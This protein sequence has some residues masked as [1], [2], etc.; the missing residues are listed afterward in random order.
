MVSHIYLFVLAVLAA[1]YIGSF[2]SHTETESHESASE[3][4]STIIEYLSSTYMEA[5]T[6]LGYNIV[7]GYLEMKKHG[8]PKD[9]GIWRRVHNVIDTP[10]VRRYGQSTI[11]LERFQR[12]S[13]HGMSQAFAFSELSIKN[14]MRVMT[15]H[16]ASM[17]AT[18]NNARLLSNGNVLIF[19]EISNAQ[20]VNEE[21]YCVPQQLLRLY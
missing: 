15:W 5:L 16:S 12:I 11:W 19:V 10:I 17:N 20:L 3:Y 8:G 21:R 9:G 4:C 7:H 6:E 18:F 1:S 14:M 2:V 13:L